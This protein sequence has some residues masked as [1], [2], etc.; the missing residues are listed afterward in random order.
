MRGSRTMA[1][2]RSDFNLICVWIAKPDLDRFAV[3]TS[4]R[5]EEGE[6]GAIACLVAD[7]GVLLADLEHALLTEAGAPQAIGRRRFKHPRRDFAVPLVYV[8]EEMGVGIDPAHFFQHALP[9]LL[10]AAYVELGLHRMVRQSRGCE[11]HDA[12]G[13]Q[14]PNPLRHR[15]YSPNQT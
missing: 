12:S 7:E 9:G 4:Q 13:D 11:R 15:S 6:L 10:L 2:P 14:P 1:A 3:G 8:E 5:L